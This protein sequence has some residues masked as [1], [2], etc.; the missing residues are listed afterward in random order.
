MRRTKSCVARISSGSLLAREIGY[1]VSTDA[2]QRVVTWLEREECC[3]GD[4]CEGLLRTCQSGTRETVPMRYNSLIRHSP[5][6][7]VL[8]F[9]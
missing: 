9:E 3:A 8:S 5:R 2:D 4:K 6:R 1:M 7:S